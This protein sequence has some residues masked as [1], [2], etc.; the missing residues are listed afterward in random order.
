M[1]SRLV[2]FSPPSVSMRGR[3]MHCYCG[4]HLLTQTKP[5]AR[6]YCT[7]QEWSNYTSLPRTGD[8]R[9]TISSNYSKGLLSR[10]MDI[11]GQV[12]FGVTPF[13]SICPLAWEVKAHLA[14]R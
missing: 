1:D 9:L 13:T 11:N 4:R 7:G 8:Q 3:V 6:I 12:V 5:S 14:K 10:C 2:P